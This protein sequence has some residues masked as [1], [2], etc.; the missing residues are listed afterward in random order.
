MSIEFR[1]PNGHRLSCPDDRAGKPGKCPKCQATFM[2]PSAEA[3]AAVAG[4]SGVSLAAVTD[5]GAIENLY[6]A[7]GESAGPDHSSAAPEVVVFLCPNGHK[8]N[9]PASMQGRP[10]KCPH[11]GAK[12]IIPTYDAPE[13]HDDDLPGY[14]EHSTPDSHA[15]AAEEVELEV[16]HEPAHA[17]LPPEL[18]FD[19]TGGF[20]DGGYEPRDANRQEGIGRVLR[21]LME[22]RPEEPLVEIFLRS[23]ASFVAE[24]LAHTAPEGCGL[25]AHH[26]SDGRYTLSIIPWDQI[27]RVQLRKVS[28]L[29]RFFS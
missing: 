26:E 2:V 1:C 21:E 11:C 10:G 17:G 27:E 18:P 20:V 22:Q 19:F 14:G 8:L 15:E 13:Q 6:D 4:G 29:P 25:F 28:R 24:R 9:C 12:F 16:L 23:G 5:S 7:P 3:A